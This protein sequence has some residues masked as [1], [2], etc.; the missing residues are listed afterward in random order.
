MAAHLGL[1]A[2]SGDDAGSAASARQPDPNWRSDRPVRVALA[3]DRAA[4][5]RALRRLLDGHD[6]L[7]V[8]GEHPEPSASEQSS[9]SGLP[10]H[11][12]A[13]QAP[14]VVVLELQTPGEASIELIGALRAHD[15]T[16][17]IVVLAADSNPLFVQRALDAGAHC[18]VLRQH[19]APALPEAVRSAAAGTEFVSPLLAAGLESLRDASREDG[20]T[21]REIEVLRLT[22]LGFTGA[23]IAGQL[24]LSRRTVESHR[25]SIHRKL[26][27]A[28][29]A[30]LVSYALARRLIRT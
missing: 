13:D 2:P 9:Q 18:Y 21:L 25:A 27:L 10:H 7:Q 8:I 12:P 1:V 28:S 17:R 11:A 16:I 30:E 15:P 20:L 29:R 23:Q 19:A 14:D 4:A 22:A 3:D 5:Q 6:G 26:G 24:R